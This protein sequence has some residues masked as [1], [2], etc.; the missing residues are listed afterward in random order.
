MDLPIP[1]DFDGKR[2]LLLN[3]S[4]DNKNK[5]QKEFS[6]I[7]LESQQ[8]ISFYKNISNSYHAKFNKR[9][10]AT[11]QNQTNIILFSAKSEYVTSQQ[12]FINSNIFKENRAVKY[13]SAKNELNSDSDSGGKIL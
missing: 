5:L 10:F 1:L 7:N 13:L 11:I 4:I 2:L 12:S 9:G 6:L 3:N 8:K